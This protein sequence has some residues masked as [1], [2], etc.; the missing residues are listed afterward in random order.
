MNEDAERAFELCRT[1][2]SAARATRSRYRLSP[3]TPLELVVRADASD[4]EALESLRST[5]EGL[6]NTASLEIATYA[7]K[8]A[9]SIGIVD[10]GVET[11]VVLEG[12]VDL[13][14]EKARLEKEIASAVKELAGCEKTLSNHGFLAK[15]NPAVVQ[16]K[17]DRASEL[18]ETLEALRVQVAD[19]S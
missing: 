9:A 8:P 1:V 7:A 2:V 19:F 3:K 13:A 15:A 14:A 18:K 10:N 12:M 17:K 11:F 5:I 16:K 6:A 4:I